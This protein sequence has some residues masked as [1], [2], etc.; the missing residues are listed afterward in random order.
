MKTNSM[1]NI[2]RVHHGACDISDHDELI[3]FFKD[4][5]V[6]VVGLGI[7]GYWTSIWLAGVG[8]RVT[9]S[10]VRPEH[11]MAQDKVQKLKELGVNIQAGYHNR[12]TFLISKVIVI[13]PGVP[14]DMPLILEARRRG[15]IIM[16]ELELGSR[17]IRQPIIAVTGTNGKT[18]VT[19]LL[20]EIIRGSGKKV[21]VGGNIGSPLME[22]VAT[23]QSCDYVVAE[24]SSFQ[25]DT[26]ETF[27]PFVS[28]LLNIAP[29]HLD[30]Y[31]DYESYI[32][33][34]LRIFE[35]QG[36]G[37]YAVINDEDKF[38]STFSPA[39]PVQVLRYGLKRVRGRNAYMEGHMI[40]VSLSPDRSEEFTLE[41]FRLPGTHNRQ[42]VMAAILASLCIGID[43]KTIQDTINTYDGLPHRLERVAFLDGVTFYNDSKATNVDAVVRAIESFDCPIILIAGGLHKGASYRPIVDIGKGKI[44]KAI[45]IGEAKD[46][47]AKDLE[48]QIPYVKAAHMQEAVSKAILSAI[49]GDVVLLSPA[50]ASFD[51]FSDYRER[52]EAFKRAVKGIVN[53]KG[54]K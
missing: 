18:T 3:R 21:F 35:N 27:S 48:G 36:S 42:N 4:N 1:K 20:G 12:D 44:K 40:K 11:E 46:I 31:P 8:A 22:Y 9:I 51:M 14:H 16:G 33:S 45:L 38:L 25:L 47:I 19:S 26:I 34:K 7:S 52:G 30:R 24:V 6:L 41:H 23:G 5:K 39:Q 32:Q 29:D 28:I 49:S 13:S 10:D 54:Q 50:C 37:Q 15:S 43:G 2:G 17:L 53:G